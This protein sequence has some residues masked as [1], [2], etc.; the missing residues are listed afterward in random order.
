MLSKDGDSDGANEEY[1]MGERG[2]E[3]LGGRRRASVRLRKREREENERK[4]RKV[5]IPWQKWQ[6]PGS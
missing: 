6:C 2:D 4:G 1:G 5:S 3:V